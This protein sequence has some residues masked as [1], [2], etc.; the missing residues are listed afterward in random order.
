M[1]SALLIKINVAP[2]TVQLKENEAH[3]EFWQ[4]KMIM[5]QAMRLIGCI[6]AIQR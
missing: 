1:F 5:A 4:C 3:S 2:P 6:S